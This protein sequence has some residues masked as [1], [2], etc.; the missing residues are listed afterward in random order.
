M[1]KSSFW[2]CNLSVLAS[3]LI[4]LFFAIFS[5]YMFGVVLGMG[6]AG[7]WFAF[8]LDENSRGIVLAWRWHAQKWIKRVLIPGNVK[9]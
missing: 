2:I 8:A 5:G 7:M 3:L 9:I 6:L 1:Q 4:V